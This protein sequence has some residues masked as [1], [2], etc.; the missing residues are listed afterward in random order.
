M[1]M[2]FSILYIAALPS[3]YITLNGIPYDKVP[4]ILSSGSFIVA[5]MIIVELLAKNSP[6]Y[7]LTLTMA[8]DE[9]WSLMSSGSFKIHIVL[10]NNK[11][12]FCCLLSGSFDVSEIIISRKWNISVTDK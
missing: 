8:G 10:H 1:I 4:E 7:K 6:Q 11:W 9:W 12:A 3:T 5:G 2:E